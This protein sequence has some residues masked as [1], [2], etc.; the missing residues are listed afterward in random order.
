MSIIA[1][2]PIVAAFELISDRPSL[3]PSVAVSRPAAASASAPSISAPRYSA[4]PSPIS[5]SAIAD[6]G[7]RSA[8]LIDPRLG[9]T[10]WTAAFSIAVSASNTDGEIPDP[11]MRIPARRAN[12][13]ARTVSVGN[14]EPT[15]T[16]RARSAL[17]W[18]WEKESLD[19]CVAE[20]A[21][22]GLSSLPVFAPSAEVRP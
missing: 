12:M 19:A 8:T 18:Y 14:G 7:A 5:G 15:P 9:I 21:P 6:N 20:L 13:M 1:A 17:I 3:G 22:S 2:A 11:P 4:R 16:L 10:G